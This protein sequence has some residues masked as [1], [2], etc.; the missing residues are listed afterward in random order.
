MKIIDLV[1]KIKSSPCSPCSP[2]QHPNENVMKS[3]ENNI[4]LTYLTYLCIT[5]DFQKYANALKYFFFSL[6]PI[7]YPLIWSICFADLLLNEMK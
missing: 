6:F 4:K 1:F 2:P 5:I 3:V 7:K